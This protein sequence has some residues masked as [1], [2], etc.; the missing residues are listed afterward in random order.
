MMRI[1]TLMAIKRGALRITRLP[2]EKLRSPDTSRELA[3]I[4]VML[5]DVM[6]SGPTVQT[7]AEATLIVEN[8]A[9]GQSGP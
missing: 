7:E 9:G 1:E 2:P 5:V 3:E 6:S 4:I 8:P